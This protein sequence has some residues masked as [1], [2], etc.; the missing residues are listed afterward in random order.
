MRLRTTAL[1]FTFLCLSACSVQKTSQPNP[2]ESADQKSIREE[3]Y[4]EYESEICETNPYQNSGFTSLEECKA[5]VLCLSHLFVN[6][7]PEDDVPSLARV[8]RERGGESGS[9]TYLQEHPGIE[10]LF[11]VKREECL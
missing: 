2:N 7:I 3:Y 8:M 5:V 4:K 6:L 1:V 9:M 10:S 11:T